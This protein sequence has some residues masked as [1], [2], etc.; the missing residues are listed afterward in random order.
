MS[1]PPVPA[2]HPTEAELDAFRR[3][4]MPPDSIVKLDA[5]LAGCE[6]CRARVASPS[7]LRRRHAEM[8]A[9]LA[10][11]VDHVSEDEVQAFVNGTLP[12]ARRHEIE[13]HLRECRACAAEIDDLRN[14]AAHHR[15]VTPRLM[16]GLAAAAVLVLAAGG[17]WLLRSKPAAPIVTLVDVGSTIVLD[18]RGTLAGL[19]ALTVEESA[20]VREALGTGTLS[21][22]RA[23]RDLTGRRLQL[24]GGGSTAVPF[25]VVS[26]VAT[27][28]LDDRPRLRWTA[29]AGATHYIVTIQR[30]LDGT[31]IGSGPIASTEWAVDRALARGAT[32]TWQVAAT[33]GGSDVV[34][35]GSRDAP[36]QFL[37]LDDASAARLRDLPP[38]HVAR[39]ALYARAGA[40]DDAVRELA[41]ARARN[42]NAAVLDKWQSQLITR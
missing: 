29:A 24:M 39:A 20:A 16:Y 6:S 27:A 21:L 34:A 32:Y 41:E 14:F 2:T 36:A 37:V 28:V 31:T 30:V 26:P 8:T 19:D 18:D 12:T 10:E 11:A 13:R 23:V 40:V 15:R 4:E 9:S 38:S 1:D 33:I 7:E 25:Q 3:R 22:P 17:A 35:P 5:H 42:P